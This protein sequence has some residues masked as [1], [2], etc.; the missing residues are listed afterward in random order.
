[1]D[2]FMCYKQKC[3][4]VSLNLAHPVSGSDCCSW[5]AQ[6]DEVLTVMP[7][8]ELITAYLLM[9]CWRCWVAHHSKSVL[10]GF[11]CSQ[12][13]TQSIYSQK[14]VNNV[15]FVSFIVFCYTMFTL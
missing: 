7:T 11:T 5:P 4:V 8:A 9:W 13:H 6:A 14:H 1:V 10:D 12:L 3:K 2:A 15:G